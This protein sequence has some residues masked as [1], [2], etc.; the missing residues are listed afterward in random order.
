MSVDRIIRILMAACGLVLAYA[1]L[2]VLVPDARG[3]NGDAEPEQLVKLRSDLYLRATRV[4]VADFADDVNQL[5]VSSETCRARHGSKAC[6][7][8]DKALESSRLEDRFNYY[9]KG[10]VEAQAKVR[11]AKID[12]RNW[13]GSETP[14]QPEANHER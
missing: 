4:P 6:G 14:N 5:G 8:P 3:E 10:P 12:R 1:F 11:S 13:V 2:L 7:L 9:V